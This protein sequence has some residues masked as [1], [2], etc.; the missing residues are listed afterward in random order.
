MLVQYFTALRMERVVLLEI[1]TCVHSKTS[2]KGV[3][4][5]PVGQHTLEN[6][7]TIQGQ[8]RFCMMDALLH[9]HSTDNSRESEPPSLAPGMLPRKTC[10][11]NIWFYLNWRDLIRL[12][13][14]KKDHKSE[15]NL[16]LQLFLL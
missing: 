8:G 3:L 10:S 2:S 4:V 9:F 7:K 6:H 14:S 1:T 11:I 15:S 16:L 13:Q 12:D 5:V